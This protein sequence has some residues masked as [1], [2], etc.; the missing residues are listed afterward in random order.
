MSAINWPVV[1][2]HLR[3]ISIA[4]NGARPGTVASIECGTFVPRSKRKSPTPRAE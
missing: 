3:L 1:S 2:P 4:I